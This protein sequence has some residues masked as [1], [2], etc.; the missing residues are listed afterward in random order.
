MSRIYI[1]KELKQLVI[2]KKAYTS[3][4]WAKLVVK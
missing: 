3:V 2:S 1:K 4:G